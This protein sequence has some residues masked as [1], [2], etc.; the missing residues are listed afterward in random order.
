VIWGA[1]IMNIYEKESFARGNSHLLG[2]H[3]VTVKDRKLMEITGVKKLHSFDS[4][5]FV[6]ETTMGILTIHGQ[7]LDMKNLELDKGE[8][9]IIGYIA[10][11]EYEDSGYEGSGKGLFSKLFK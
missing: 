3:Q 4:E 6:I 11:H 1:K 10:N 8:L 5:M 2:H 7:D 9:S